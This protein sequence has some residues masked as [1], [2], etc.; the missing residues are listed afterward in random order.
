MLHSSA[1]RTRLYSTPYAP[2]P[3]YLIVNYICRCFRSEPWRLKS[4]CSETPFYIHEELLRNS[5]PALYSVCE[6]KWAESQERVYQFDKAVSE[7]TISCFLSYAYHGDYVSSSQTAGLIALSSIELALDKR[8]VAKN[9]DSK[10]A[11]SDKDEKYHPVSSHSEDVHPLLL[12]IQLYVFA[13]TYII[14]NLQMLT[15]GKIRESLQKLSSLNSEGVREEVFDLLEYAF[16]NLREEDTLLTF[17]SLYASNKLDVLKL[18][19]QRLNF[20]F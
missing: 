9:S 8:R 10:V 1:V 17:L 15:R 20:L 11:D 16:D 2:T 13:D 19:S 4:E 14:P 5:S 12:H 7:Q 3:V 18:S 6:R